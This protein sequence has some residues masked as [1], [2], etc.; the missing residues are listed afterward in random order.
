MTQR[1]TWR[2]DPI[3]DGST[4]WFYLQ[5]HA[6]QWVEQSKA[7]LEQGYMITEE[8]QNVVDAEFGGC[9]RYLVVRIKP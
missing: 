5:A 9:L 7:V 4:A 6:G 2:L 1:R 8:C 3:G